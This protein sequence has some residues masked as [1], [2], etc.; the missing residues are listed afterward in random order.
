MRIA[1]TVG[2]N[3]RPGR[4]HGDERIRICA[5]GRNAIAAIPAEHVARAQLN[6]GSDPQDFTHE[7]V[8]L[9]R[10]RVRD[11]G[12]LSACT[13]ADSYIK[14]AVIVLAGLGARIEHQIP[15]R[16]IAVIADSQDLASRAFECGVPN[17]AVRP[18]NDDG[19]Q[20]RLYGWRIDGRGDG[21]SLEFWRR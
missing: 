17:V 13:V 21:I 9:L 4:G 12:R 2:K 3:F 8:E 14:V 18:F 19:F 11:S 1:E 16:V 10:I 7:D 20:V 15:D 5:G 6:V